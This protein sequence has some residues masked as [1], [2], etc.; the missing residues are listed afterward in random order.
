[1][2]LTLSDLLFPHILYS[3]DFRM[4]GIAG[5]LQKEGSRALGEEMVVHGGG[6]VDL[7]TYFGSVPDSAPYRK[8]IFLCDVNFGILRGPPKLHYKSGA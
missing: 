3:S 1:M 8:Y 2:V 4:E 7:K 6:F 5:Q